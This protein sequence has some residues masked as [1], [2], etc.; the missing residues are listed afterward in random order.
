MKMLMYLLMCLLSISYANAQYTLRLVVNDVATKKLDDIYV[1]GNFNN[2]NMHDEKY[3]LKPFGT[4]RRAIVLK[5]I[6]V[7]DYEFKFTRGSQ[8]KVETTAK[9]QEISPHKISLKEDASLDFAI[10]GWKD[11][12]PDKPKPY[13]ATAQ[14]SLMDSAFAIPQLNRRRSIWVYLPKGYATSKK[15]YPVI[16]M[17]DGQNLFNEQ[18]A[19]QGEWGLDECLDS[20]AA[21]HRKECIVVAIASDA[22]VR[23][24]E[25]NPYEEGKL[26]DEFLANTL[27]PFIDKKYHTQKEP[28]HTFIAGS[29]IG[30]VISLYTLIKYPNVFGGVGLFSPNFAMAQA[31]Y[32]EVAKATWAPLHPKFYFFAGDKD[33]DNTVPEMDKM[34]ATIEKKGSYL[35]RRVM[36]PIAKQNEAAWRKELP[37]FF[38]FIMP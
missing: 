14:V 11:D 30:A 19:M 22:K 10:P 15:A 36:S 12:Y 3:K 13:T 20:L 16:Y 28:A 1:A 35:T 4:T 23:A 9:G 27:K 31:M 2:W 33:R 17:Q 26:Y 32:D 21:K 7:G 29:N 37:G 5:E 38:E 34:I 24:K 8:D 6:A 25:Y 18:T